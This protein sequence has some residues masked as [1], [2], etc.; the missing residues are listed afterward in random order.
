MMIFLHKFLLHYVV[1]K[2][3]ENYFYIYI[4]LIG[5]IIIRVGKLVYYVFEKTNIWPFFHNS[6][7][8]FMFVFVM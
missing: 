2:I 3:T 1:Q 4:F 8:Y 7:K 5:A 6:K